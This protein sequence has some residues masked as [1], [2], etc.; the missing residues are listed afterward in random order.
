MT[1]VESWVMIYAAQAEK[2]IASPTMVVGRVRLY[3][4]IHIQFIPNMFE[5]ISL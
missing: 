5:S 4:A 3:D 1:F 2:I